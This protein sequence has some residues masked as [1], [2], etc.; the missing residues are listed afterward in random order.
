MR[1]PDKKPRKLR[2]APVRD[3]LRPSIQPSR[4]DYHRAHDP[5]ILQ[6]GKCLTCYK[7]RGSDGSKRYCR[8]CCNRRNAQAR[9][10]KALNRLWA[11]PP[12]AADAESS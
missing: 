12:P 4:A 11:S 9:A 1:G 8:A 3:G 2:P 10:A 6:A 7:P 5:A